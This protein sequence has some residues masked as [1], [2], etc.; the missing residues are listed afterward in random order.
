MMASMISGSGDGIKKASSCT[1][2]VP[3][4]SI[5]RAPSIVRRY[6]SRGDGRR[7]SS[8]GDSYSMN[9][10]SGMLLSEPLRWLA[11]EW[12][13]ALMRPGTRRWCPRPAITSAPSGGGT[14]PMAVIRCPVT[15]T[16]AGPTISPA[17]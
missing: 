8:V 11:G 1:E 5:S 9:I 13:C 15:S 16:S 14:E 3:V 4:R 17:W 6:A 7:T 12:K 10:S 2:V